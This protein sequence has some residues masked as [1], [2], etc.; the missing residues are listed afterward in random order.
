[1]VSQRP[2]H[3]VLSPSPLPGGDRSRPGRRPHRG[4]SPRTGLEPAVQWGHRLRRHWR[5]SPRWPGAS[6]PQGKLRAPLEETAQP[7]MEQSTLLVTARHAAAPLPCALRPEPG[8]GG[9]RPAHRCQIV[10]HRM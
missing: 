3:G 5:A 6:S 9:A 7:A 10:W 8:P 4:R 1:M 2:S